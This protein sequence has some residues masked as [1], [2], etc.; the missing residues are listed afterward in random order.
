MSCLRETAD[1]LLVDIEVSPASG[2]FEITSYNEWRNRI[3][4]KIRAPP[5]KGRANREIIREFSATFNTK[6][7]IV[8][9]HKSR[10]KT[11]K[12]YGI[13]ADTFRDLLEEKFGL[14]LPP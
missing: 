11:L 10:H 9:G 7:D 14:M 12:L 3:E 5:E 1:A 13:D 8:S 4:V 6:A 2:R